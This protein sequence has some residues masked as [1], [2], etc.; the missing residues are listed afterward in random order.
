MS[1]A[2]VPAVVCAAG[3][4]SAAIPLPSPRPP[5]PPP[6]RRLQRRGPQERPP[7]G[8]R[9]HLA[10]PLP[11]RSPSNGR[12]RRDPK[13]PTEKEDGPLSP[14]PHPPHRPGPRLPRVPPPPFP[15][16]TEA[17]YFLNPPALQPLSSRVDG[18][19]V[20]RLDKLHVGAGDEQH[21]GRRRHRGRLHRIHLRGRE[22]ALRPHARPHRG[23]ELVGGS[24]PREPREGGGV[25]AGLD[26]WGDAIEPS[27]GGHRISA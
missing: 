21:P 7:V 24:R 20:D 14:S 19:A 22:A 9:K 15:S 5:E 23:G 4:W 27:G 10:R 2:T 13:R 25:P 26:R 18:V 3:P 16:A 12:R 17:M 11:K 8:G 1:V 6:R